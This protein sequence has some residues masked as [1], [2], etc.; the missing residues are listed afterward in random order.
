M[1]NTVRVATHQ[2]KVRE[3]FIFSRSGNCQGIWKNVREIVKRGKCQGISCK[4]F[5]IHEITWFSDC[6]LN[7]WSSWLITLFPVVIKFDK[8]HYMS[9]KVSWVLS[10]WLKIPGNSRNSRSEMFNVVYFIESRITTLLLFILSSVF[11]TSV[12]WITHCFLIFT[13][14]ILITTCPSIPINSLWPS[15]TTWWHRFVSTLALVIV[16]CLKAPSHSLNQCWLIRNVLCMHLRTISKEGLMNLVHSSRLNFW[17]YYHS[18][19]M[20]LS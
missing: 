6:K 19:H 13:F 20:P 15:D 10:F 14:I 12:F 8:W 16:C 17:N 18:S 5:V 3:K 11:L 9:E 7:F 2:G 4:D 1:V